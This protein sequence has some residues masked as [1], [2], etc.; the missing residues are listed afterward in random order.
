MNQNHALQVIGADSS[1]Q[2]VKVVLRNALN[3]KLIA[4]SSKP[5]PTGTEVDPEAWWQALQEAISEAT[6]GIGLSCVS[7]I[8]IAGQQHGMVVL[9][10]YGEVIRPALLWNDTR[11]AAAAVALNHEF[12]DIHNRVG[13]K[14]VA[15]FTAAK[16]RWLRD[17]EPENAKR[18]RAVAL[19]H[20]WLS[21]KLSGSKNI[22]TL[23][24]DRSDAS[25]TGYF[26]PVTNIYDMEIFEAALGHQNVVLPRILNINEPGFDDGKI[27]IGPGA[28]DNAAGAFGVGAQLGDLVISLGTS[29]TA[30]IV[31]K[32]PTSDF[33]GEV[34]GFADLTG[35]YLPLVCTLNAA[36]IFDTTAKLLRVSLDELGELALSA[37]PGAGGLTLLPHFDGERTPD[38][39][40]S[41]GTITGITNENFTPPNLARAAIEGVVGSM[42]YAVEALKKLDVTFNRIILIGGA[43]RNLAVQKILTEFFEA[44]IYLP[45]SGEY[46]ADGA[47]R[48]AAWTLSDS[49]TAPMWNENQLTVVKALQFSPEV[50]KKYIRAI[51]AI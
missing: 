27:K 12:P 16:L 29:G 49:K 24:T 46:V 37:Q 25:G 5:H 51:S 21:W 33:R 13:S 1:T 7:A 45:T 50:R 32:T 3:G 15:S 31:S 9:D 2:S 18:V 47:A 44:D 36:K 43:S 41:R 42:A 17:N 6:S 22:E 30:F 10:E 4:S 23:F 35:N 48:Q 20:D 26:N 14:L 8:S 19:P 34:A 39:P 28:G 38:R 40:N 11:S